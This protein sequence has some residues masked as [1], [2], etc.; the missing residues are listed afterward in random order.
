[1]RKRLAF[2]YRNPVHFVSLDARL[3]AEDWDVTQVRFTFSPMAVWRIWRAVSRSD[4][5][6]V[7]FGNV[8]AALAVLFARIAGKKSVVVAGGYDADAVPE[9][10]YGL[11]L[12][13]IL[14][15]FARFAFTRADL[16]LPV[17][18]YMERMLRKVCSPR[19]C[20]TVPNAV[21]LPDVT[22]DP[23]AK[24]DMVLTI[25]LVHKGS[26]PI[27]GHYRFLEAASL[28]P[29]VRF[30]LYGRQL[31]ESAGELRRLAPPNVT[32]VDDSGRASLL[33]HL[34]RARIYAQFSDAESFGVALVEAMRCGATPVVTP[35]GAMPEIVGDC[36]VVAR[37]MDAEALAQAVR[38]ALGRT[39]AVNR[40]AMEL[41]QAYTLDAR[42]SGLRRM[43]ALLGFS[44]GSGLS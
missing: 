16:V 6:F 12:H 20:L 1:M 2:V 28:L 13:P 21:D 19:A 25:G 22:P 26:S 8:W 34:L 37:G 43:A 23:D 4:A 31:D 39:G 3:L 7:W 30:V 33:D 29:G 18:P 32:L 27:K 36:G 40:R 41:S 24:Q 9:I 44:P 35:R 11:P 38:E 10:G 42:R 5:V 14:R 15:H 17:S